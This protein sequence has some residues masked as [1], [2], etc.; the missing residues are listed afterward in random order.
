MRWI[1]GRLW[2]PNAAYDERANCALR[3]GVRAHH[4]LLASLLTCYLVQV[5][6]IPLASEVI[7]NARHDLVRRLD[8]YRAR[9]TE[10][11][12]RVIKVIINEFLH[13][14]RRQALS[15]RAIIRSDNTIFSESGAI[16]MA[17]DLLSERGY[18]V[19]LDYNKNTLPMK[20]N[21]QTGEIT[22]NVIKIYEFQIDFPKPTIRRGL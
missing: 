21:L 20:V 17:L 22:H 6:R 9:N 5:R 18:T 13:I 2:P 10:L 3:C 14:I 16:D 19:T 7:T 4:P 12:D 8:H 15:G 11:F 1:E